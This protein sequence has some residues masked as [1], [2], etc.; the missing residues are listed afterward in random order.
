MNKRPVENNSFFPI[1]YSS[2]E[3]LFSGLP[4][5]NFPF[6]SFGLESSLKER[7]TNA[8]RIDFVIGGGRLIK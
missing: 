1:I 8:Y 3:L 4:I 7:G 6:L 5:S 2:L